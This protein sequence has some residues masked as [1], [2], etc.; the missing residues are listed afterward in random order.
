MRII[1]LAARHTLEKREPLLIIT[2]GPA[3]KQR[4]FDSIRL[5]LRSEKVKADY[6]YFCD[7]IDRNKCTIQ[8][9]ESLR[10]TFIDPVLRVCSRG[11]DIIGSH[12]KWI[13]LEDIIQEEFKSDESN[14]GLQIWFKQVVS[15]CATHE[16][17][18]ETRIT[19]TGT[20]KAKND[21][22]QFLIDELKYPDFTEK[23]LELLDGIFP[24]NED[25]TYYED[26]RIDIDITK[27][28]YKTLGCPNWPLSRLLVEKILKPLEFRTQ[29]QN[30][31]ID[32][33]GN[34]FNHTMYN[35][36]EFTFHAL[37]TSII[38]TIDPAF[39]KSTSADNTAICVLGRNTQAPRTFVLLEMFA[40][41]IKSLRKTLLSIYEKYSEWK[42]IKVSC[43]ANFLQK[44]MVVDKL[45]ETLPFTVAPFMNKGEKV[46]RIQSLH[47]PMVSKQ[48]M[49]WDKCQGKEAFREELF[50]WIPKASSAS[51]KDDML[52]ALQMGYEEFVRLT[53]SFMPSSGRTSRDFKDDYSRY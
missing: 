23:A 1:A 26:G 50:S 40:G 10:G 2:S 28:T 36:T 25:I 52:D 38:I 43:E 15:F 44:I 11:A 22:Y 33:F 7:S 53:G 46:L 17:T 32:P 12:P 39:G 20:R 29:M 31:P 41:K 8:L 51:R 30:E 9:N 42:I 19:G 4:I 37:D 48:I 18:H 13:H 27:G 35:E 45:N 3:S 49:I 21:F 34:F 16:E 14:E 24:T 6:G 5:I 47:D